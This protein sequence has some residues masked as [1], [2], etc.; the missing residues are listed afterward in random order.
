VLVSICSFKNIIVAPSVAVRQTK[1]IIHIGL[2]DWEFTSN[3]EVY[4]SI[5]GSYCFL[6]EET[7][8]YKYREHI[9]CT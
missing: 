2:V 9:L 1:K 4:D 7:E 5:S 3:S 6:S 8:N